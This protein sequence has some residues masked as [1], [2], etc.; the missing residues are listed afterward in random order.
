[1]ELELEKIIPMEKVFAM[2]ASAYPEGTAPGKFDDLE[3]SIVDELVTRIAP[4]LGMDFMMQAGA[5]GVLLAI[6]LVLR[7]RTRNGE[8]LLEAKEA[9]GASPD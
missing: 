3:E 7:G 1:M 5:C 4:Y 9:N 2:I 6:E 8:G